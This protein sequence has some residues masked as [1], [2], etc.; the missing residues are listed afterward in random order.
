MLT[1][2]V[3]PRLTLRMF[4]DDCRLARNGVIAQQPLTSVQLMLLDCQ[5]RQITHPVQRA[6]AERRTRV[7]PASYLESDE[8]TVRQFWEMAKQ[9]DEQAGA[10]NRKSPTV[11][12]RR[13]SEQSAPRR[14]VNS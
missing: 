6:F 13:R 5:Y 14:S 9:K 7:N 10:T 3:E 11:L 8:T 1:L 2:F 4:L 12:I